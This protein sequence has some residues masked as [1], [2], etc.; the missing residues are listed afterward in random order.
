[1][2]H[3]I[4]LTEFERELH[5]RGFA[6]SHHSL[7]Q[8]VNQVDFS[9]LKDFPESDRFSFYEALA[10]SIPPGSRGVEDGIQILGED[11]SDQIVNTMSGKAAAQRFPSSRIRDIWCKLFIGGCP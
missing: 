2:Q 5:R 3:G 11:D 10:E 9:K 4:Y 1:V 6:I 7:G 8:L